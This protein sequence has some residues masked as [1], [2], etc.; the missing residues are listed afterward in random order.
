MEQAL[1]DSEFYF[2]LLVRGPDHTPQAQRAAGARGAARFHRRVCGA[3]AE[4]TLSGVRTVL[5]VALPVHT[6]TVLYLYL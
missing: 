3:E 2:Y 5:S 4:G 1:V 6:R